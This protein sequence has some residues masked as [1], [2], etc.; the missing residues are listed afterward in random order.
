M[1]IKKQKNGS[2]LITDTN[3]ANEPIKQVYYFYSK[4]TAM[5]HFRQFKKDEN[6]KRF[7]GQ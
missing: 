2:L 3:K 7:I 1:D 6:N 5:K 4:Q